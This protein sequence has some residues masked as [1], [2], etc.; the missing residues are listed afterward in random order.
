[1]QG[2]VYDALL[3]AAGMLP[4]RADSL[5]ETATKVRDRTIE[6]L[7][8][9]ER[10]YFGLGID[11]NHDEEIRVIRTATANPAALLDSGFF[12]KLPDKEKEAYVSGI[13]EEIM[14]SA[15]LT[16]AGIRSRS[17]DAAGLVDFWDY[18]GSFASW[19]KET[20]DIAKGLRRQGFPKLAKQLENRLLNVFLK[21][22]LYME[23]VFVNKHGQV[24]AT[25]P[26]TNSHG[27]ILQIDSANQPERI[28]AWTVSAIIAILNRPLNNQPPWRTQKI[29]IWAK[30]LEKQVLADMRQ[31][32]LYINPFTL[33]SR[34]PTHPY[35]L[36]RKRGG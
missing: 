29:P 9:P 30:D 24:L 10:H 18:H 21:S 22:R 11:Y 33:Y 17:L 13:V 12:D 4:K 6:L 1:V 7:W 3:L 5:R 19:P 36:T 16:D 15:F 20:Y 28:Q 14:S 34:Y 35:R 31:I 26:S 25:T 27:E 2:L 32:N 8:L 23:F